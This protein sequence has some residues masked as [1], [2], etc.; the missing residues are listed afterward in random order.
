MRDNIEKARNNT[1]KPLNLGFFG[2]NAVHWQIR[3]ENS[4]PGSS[5]GDKERRTIVAYKHLATRTDIGMNDP[6]FAVGGSPTNYLTTNYW[7]DNNN[8]VLMGTQCPF[9]N[10]F[11][12]PED[13]L[14]G[15]MTDLLNVSGEDDFRFY[16]GPNPVTW[17]TAGITDTVTPILKIIGYEADRVFDENLPNYTNRTPLVKLGD[18]FFN[19]PNRSHAV[20]YRIPNAGRVF[21]AGT[22][23]W[24]YALDQ[25]GRDPAMGPVY[26]DHHAPPDP[27][28]GFGCN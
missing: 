25:F 18:S 11:K 13:E 21:G 7:R 4:S 5:P 3:F 22:I 23:G 20:Y 24:S 10:C 14:V 9:P 26:I 28:R 2:G 6:Y 8:S 12:P 27:R 19:N 17:H 16:S 1:T 15:V